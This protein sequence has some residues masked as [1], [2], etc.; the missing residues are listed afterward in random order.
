MDK[1][2]VGERLMQVIKA[3]KL[4]QLGFADKY[5]ISKNSVGRYKANER[6]PEPELLKALSADGVN[7]NWLL[8]GEG[9]MFIE[10]RGIG[11]NRSKKPLHMELV[12]P[13]K[14]NLPATQLVANRTILLP[15][16]GQVAAGVPMPI[17]ETWEVSDFVEIPRIYL[18]GSP[19]NHF[20]F[21]VNGRSMEPNISHGDIVVIRYEVDWQTVENRVCA[22][23]NE[24][25]VT[26][27]KVVIDHATYQVIL[28]P[29]NLDFKPL[30]LDPNRDSAVALIGPMVLQFRL[31]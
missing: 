26:L 29:Y 19:E 17:P 13:A 16:A 25:G 24:D 15:L 22:V 30:I 8:T 18:A 28:Q 21:Q 11:F 20:V 1:N 23:R 10:D 2:G 31:Y 9:D 3:M 14:Y 27:K 4:N 12:Q 7:V 6:Y 5:A